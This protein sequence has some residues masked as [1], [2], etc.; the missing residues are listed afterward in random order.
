ML[1][2]AVRKN[3]QIAK[4]IL[5]S[6]YKF[7]VIGGGNMAEA[8]ITAAIGGSAGADVTTATA[9]NIIVSEPDAG[10]REK[11]AR[12][13][14]VTCVNDNLIAAACDK[15]LLAVK[16]QIMGEVLDAGVGDV[17]T[18]ET[19]VISIAAGIDTAFLD[20]HLGGR[21]RII[22]VMPNTPMMVGAGASAI[23]RGPRATAEDMAWTQKL[24]AAGGLVVEVATESLIDAVV[25]V[26]GSG[27]AYF[28]YLIEAMIAAGVAEGLDAR[29]AT[30]LAVQTCA[31][32]A[33][34]QTQ[35][36]LSPAELRQR[37]TSP[38]GT[39]QRAIETLDA[40]GVQESL[41]KAFRACAQRSRELGL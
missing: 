17:I 15:M 33:K 40:N 29:T 12:Q 10:R 27:P 1:V 2:A 39:T 23:F 36:Q 14:G 41:V 31:G 37:V 28:F 6:E 9:A 22:R 21:G 25:A 38:K 4:R 30:Q 3:T 19:L 5:M 18:N 7:G 16:P 11:L 13:L 34:L 20:S 35:T 8:I 26:S 32:A 24:F